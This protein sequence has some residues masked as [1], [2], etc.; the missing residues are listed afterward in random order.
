MKILVIAIGVIIALFICFQLYMMSTQNK[1]ENYPYT[2][3][4][5][6]ENFEIRK[7]EAR[8]FT[9]VNLGNSEYES[10]SSNGFSIL[11]GYI[12][13]GNDKKE[14]IAM[15]SPVAMSL[16]DS[17]TMMF[18]VPKNFTK[19]NLPKPNS[20]NIEFTDE[21]E[22]IVAAITFG[23]W[24]STEK[25]KK[26]KA[27]LVAALDNNN[28]QHTSQFFYLGYNPP[29]EVVNRKNEIIVE[30]DPDLDISSIIKP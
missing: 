8:L 18:M 11:A 6:F 25:I 19:E 20:S 29:Y 15:T 23:G 22:K 4:K 3:V 16:E 9:S 24:T 26:Y 21:P 28:I 2:V 13:G 30:L 12:F 5:S 14:R 7:Y 27:Q 1:I 10:A 17:M